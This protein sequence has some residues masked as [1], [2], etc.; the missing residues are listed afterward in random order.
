MRTIIKL[1]VSDA[2]LSALTD[3]SIELIYDYETIDEMHIIYADKHSFDIFV[4]EDS[5]NE[6]IDSFIFLTNLS[7]N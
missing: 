5:N 3:E 7:E 6:F 1:K 4:Y 2:L